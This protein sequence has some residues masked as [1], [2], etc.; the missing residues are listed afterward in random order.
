MLPKKVVLLGGG[1]GSSTFTSALKDL[2]I[3]LT[4]I[5]SSFDDGGSTA[6]I[7]RDYGGFALGDFRQCVMANLTLPE[8]LSNTLNFRFGRGN[9][10]GINVGNILLK[11]FLSQF[12]DQRKGVS[13]LHKKLGIKHRVLP[14]SHGFAKLQ[15]VLSNGR[16]LRDQSEI[17][18]YLNFQK[19]GIESISLNREAK[20]NPDAKKAIL[21]ADYLIFAP[22]HFFTSVLPHIYVAGF[23]DAW[24]KSGAEKIWFFNLLA[25]RGQDSFYTLKDYLIWFE[26]ILGKKVFDRVIINKKISKNILKLVE[27]RF[28]PTRVSKS[29]LKYLKQRKIKPEI[30]DVV[31]VA[32]RRQQANDLV[33]RA[34]LR[35]DVE[36]IKK[37]VE[38][39]V[40]R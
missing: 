1:V 6:A 36:K 38:R 26:N 22:G 9:L 23:R 19:A 17:A 15:A 5:V 30:A 29:D 12:K 8:E 33:M 40:L 37:Y 35:H 20:I 10:Y 16:I 39:H 25:H 32:V 18:T 21:E 7:R 28:V 13:V 11:A 14:I 24:L 31:S 4:T 3:Q 2:P 34:P 27:D